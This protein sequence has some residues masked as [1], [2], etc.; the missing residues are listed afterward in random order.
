[1]LH[2]DRPEDAV[3]RSRGFDREAQNRHVRFLLERLETLANETDPSGDELT[4]ERKDQKSF[5]ALDCAGRLID[6]VAGWALD[7]QIG[8]ALNNK[9]CF[10]QEPPTPKTFPNTLPNAKR[11][12]ITFMN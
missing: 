2:A 12:T 8:L 4:S 10:R 3:Y 7:H 11:S 6:A 1:M 5:D 9:Q